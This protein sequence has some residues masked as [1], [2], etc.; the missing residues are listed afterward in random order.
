[1]RVNNTIVRVCGEKVSTRWG[2]KKE[3]EREN[4]RERET[5]SIKLWH[6]LS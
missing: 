2:G 5:E 1:M 3:K 6:T 4:K